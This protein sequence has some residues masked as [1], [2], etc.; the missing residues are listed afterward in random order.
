MFRRKPVDDM[1]DTTKS[2]LVLPCGHHPSLMLT[3]A[4]TG[5]P[6]YCELCDARWVPVAE[7]MPESGVTVLACYVNGCG[8]PRRVRAQWIAAKSVESSP[9]SEIGEYDESADT[10]YDPEGWYERIDNW[11]DHTAV[12]IYQGTPTH[13]MPL[14]APPIDAAMQAEGA[15]R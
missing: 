10:Y 6:L 1:T 7:R 11:D 15:A 12:A 2:D 8:K 9:E 14:P 13:W 5:E 3:S 4:E